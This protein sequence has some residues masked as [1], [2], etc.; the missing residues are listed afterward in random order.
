MATC[1]QCEGTGKVKIRTK[2]V[3]DERSCDICRGSGSLV[4]CPQCGSSK[5]RFERGKI[6]GGV[7]PTCDG[8]GVKKLWVRGEWGHMHPLC[9]LCKGIGRRP[10]DCPSCRGIG[11]IPG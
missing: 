8:R 7:C 2:Y 5:S 1:A 11:Y 6:D 9:D 4:L 3:I 10:I